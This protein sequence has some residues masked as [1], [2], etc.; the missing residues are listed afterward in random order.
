[1]NKGQLIFGLIDFIIVINYTEN[2]TERRR[3]IQPPTFSNGT[4]A[5]AK[6]WL[7]EYKSVCR[8]LHYSEQEQLDELAVKLKGNALSWYSYLLPNS[9]ET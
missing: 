8:H 4:V 7:A 3:R 6:D 1:M 9:R 2:I 5:E